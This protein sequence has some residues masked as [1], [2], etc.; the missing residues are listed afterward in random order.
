MPSMDDI[1]T[2]NGIC[3]D[4]DVQNEYIKL[5]M[6]STW[7]TVDKGTWSDDRQIRIQLFRASNPR[8]T[9]QSISND[10]FRRHPQQNGRKHKSQDNA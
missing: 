6:L 3:K 4:E 2:K 8:A 9:R 10:Q 7:I 1:R 5:S